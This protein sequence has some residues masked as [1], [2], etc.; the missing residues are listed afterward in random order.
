MLEL[1]VLGGP[2]MVPL[3]ISSVLALAISL[4]RIWYFYRTRVDSDDLMEE[5]KLALQQGK[6][7]EAVQIAKRTP[8]QVAAVIAA[9]HRLPRPQPRRSEGTAGRSGP[10]RA[11]QH[12]AAA[13]HA[14]D[15][16]DRRA[17]PRFVRDCNR[18]YTNVPGF[19]CLGRLCAIT[20]RK[21]AWASRKRCL[22]TAA[23][24]IVAIPT[25]A[26]HNWIV[27]TIDRRVA[28]MNRRAGELL[29]VLEHEGGF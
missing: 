5:I 20:L 10:G 12:G 1:I 23:G 26:V 8:G 25:L 14:R 3:L 13:R 16:Y 4:E 22:T 27:N 29:D 7:L 17:P 19:G 21:S 24:L 9:G 28:D 15:N 18:Y 11:F 6:V 2:V